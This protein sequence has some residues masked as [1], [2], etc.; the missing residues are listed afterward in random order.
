MII[1]GHHYVMILLTKM[2][3]WAPFSQLICTFYYCINPSAHRQSLFKHTKKYGKCQVETFSCS[4]DTLL[5]HVRKLCNSNS[6]HGLIP[7]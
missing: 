1:L 5:R 7:L 4:Q 3:I 6:G 2:L